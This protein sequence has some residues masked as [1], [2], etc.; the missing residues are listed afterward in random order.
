MN[1]N[2]SVECTVLCR[3]VRFSVPYIPMYG[4]R[5]QCTVSV[6]IV[7]FFLA[8]FHHDIHIPNQATWNPSCPQWPLWKISTKLIVDASLVV[9]VWVVWLVLRPIRM[10]WLFNPAV[11]T[12]DCDYPNIVSPVFRPDDDFLLQCLQ[13]S[14]KIPHGFSSLVSVDIP[15]TCIIETTSGWGAWISTMGL[16]DFASECTVLVVNVRFWKPYIPMYGFCEAW[17][18]MYQ[19]YHIYYSY[20]WIDASKLKLLGLRLF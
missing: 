7:R 10:S 19:G 13:P 20:V 16:Y 15:W 18:V 14:K 8:G 11:R 1:Y 4:F 2:S 5:E 12:I 17:T 9:F 3:N 6:A